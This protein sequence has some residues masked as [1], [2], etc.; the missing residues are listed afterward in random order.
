MNVLSFGEVN[1]WQNLPSCTSSF[2]LWRPLHCFSSWRAAVPHFPSV[3]KYILVTGRHLELDRHW[4]AIVYCSQVFHSLWYPSGSLKTHFYFLMIFCPFLLE[5]T[6]IFI[7]LQ[8]GTQVNINALS[9]LACASA[10]LIS[11][12][13][14]L[15]WT[16]FF[17]VFKQGGQR[18]PDPP[19]SAWD[20]RTD[21]CSCGRFPK[22]K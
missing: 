7:P 8:N 18:R 14:W 16:D 6:L 3:T 19:A 17:A 2:I 11:A 4:Q 15:T 22:R 1:Q 20:T 13:G 9:F 5:K 10:L 21:N 12:L